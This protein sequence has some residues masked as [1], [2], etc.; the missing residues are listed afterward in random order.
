MDASADIFSFC[1]IMSDKSDR[2]AELERKKARLAQI[3]AE[4][5]SKASRKEVSFKLERTCFNDVIMMKKLVFVKHKL[6]CGLNKLSATKY[7]LK[8]MKQA[9]TL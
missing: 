1:L 7:N 6:I 4:R 9:P 2:R 5:Q 8:E 3:R